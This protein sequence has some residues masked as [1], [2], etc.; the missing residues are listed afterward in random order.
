MVDGKKKANRGLRLY[1]RIFT[2]HLSEK[3]GGEA[4]D[5]KGSCIRKASLRDDLALWGILLGLGVSPFD[6]INFH[7][8][9]PLTLHAVLNQLL[10]VLSFCCIG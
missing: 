8:N 4:L 3:W 9:L 1:D 2:A 10:E 6:Q 7:P 5:L